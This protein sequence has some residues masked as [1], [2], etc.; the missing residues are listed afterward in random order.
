M[1]MLKG[2]ATLSIAVA[3]VVLLGCGPRDV[4]EPDNPYE[5]DIEELKEI[6]P[7][8]LKYRQ[9]S[10]LKVDAHPFGI[11]AGP[12]GRIYV[13]VENGLLVYQQDRL[14]SRIELEETATC[15][16]VGAD[17][18]IFLGT[19]EQVLVMSPDRT[20][21]T[22]WDQVPE[23][24]LVTSIAV[25][26]EQVLVADA[27]NHQVLHFDLDGNL[28]AQIDGKD[29]DRD[30]PGFII[31][32][33]YFDVALD[34]QGFIWVVNPGNH[35]IECYKSNGDLRSS[36]GKSGM[37][38]DGF[39]G[40]CNPIHMAILDDGAFVTSEKGLARV[41]V[42]EP[43]GVLRAVVAGPAQLAEGTVGLDLA[44]DPTGRILVLDP[45]A[46]LVRVFEEAV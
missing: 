20:R 38:I 46:K 22:A 16:A 6:D 36:W 25:D 1:K 33:P 3:L 24:A 8:L 39:C 9:A 32:S 11:A 29:P 30:S 13:T 15:L 12:D 10:E 28:L 45:K 31:P 41:K 17:Q 37:E 7:A 40:C 35:T 34:D 43:T 5:Y 44:I 2:R 27:G 42:I 26:E 4:K 19:V 14:E 23:R 18:R 21:T